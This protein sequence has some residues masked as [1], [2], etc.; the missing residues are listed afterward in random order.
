MSLTSSVSIPKV[1][2]GK[3]KSKKKFVQNSMFILGCNAAGILNK[4]DSFKRNIEKF[5]PGVYFVQETKSRRKNQIR[6]TEY[7]VF[8]HVRTSPT[9]Q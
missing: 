9:V 2:R 3:R 8:E 7:E 4:L 6:L 5:R 1:K